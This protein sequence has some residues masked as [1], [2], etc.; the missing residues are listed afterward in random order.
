MYAIIEACGK[1][2]KVLPGKTIMVEKLS[3]DKGADVTLDKVLVITEENT[4]IY[5]SPYIN[6]A[7]VLASVEDTVKAPKVIVYKQRPRKVYR[8][9]RGHRQSYTALKIKEIVSGG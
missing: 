3:L 1:Q 7:K 8:K 4:S 2:Y 9:R 5:G 6:G